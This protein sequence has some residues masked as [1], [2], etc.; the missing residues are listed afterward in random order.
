MFRRTLEGRYRLASHASALLPGNCPHSPHSHAEEEILIL[1]AGELDLLL[2][3]DGPD[4]PVL[5]ERLQAGDFV[6]YPAGFLHSLESVGP[7]TANYL[8]FKWS[9]QPSGSPAPMGFQCHRGVFASR[10]G[11]DPEKFSL[12]RLFEGP[13]HILHKLHCHLSHLP[14]GKGYP[15]HSDPYDVAIVMLDGEVETIGS[16][17]K[18]YD[19]IFYAAGEPHGM[20]NPGSEIARYIVFEFHFDPPAGHKK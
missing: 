17:P 4:S 11:Y 1:L 12:R 19:V 3:E 20:F 18:P 6:Y 8:M 2:P 7:A 13:T 14:P 5:R 10:E 16:R 15:S 9:G